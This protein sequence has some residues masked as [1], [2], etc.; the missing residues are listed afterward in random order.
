MSS[1]TFAVLVC[2]AFVIWYFKR[3]GPET[4]GSTDSGSS[5]GTADRADLTSI[6]NKSGRMTLMGKHD[7]QIAL[8]NENMDKFEG[9]D[10]ATLY[11]LRGGSYWMKNDFQ[12]ALADY[13]A[14][15]ELDDQL[16]NLTNYVEGLDKCG[17][18][19]EAKTY[20]ELAMKNPK[21]DKS[22]RKKMQDVLDKQA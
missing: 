22:D 3:K 12:A 17:M 5:T 18:L 4:S 8:V 21:L 13:K 11:M 10:K 20:A 2:I 7:D 9:E 15:Y 19:A 14:A 16:V 6:I 1:G